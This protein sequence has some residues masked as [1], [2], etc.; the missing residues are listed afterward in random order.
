[1]NIQMIIEHHYIVSLKKIRRALTLTK[2][3]EMIN[4]VDQKSV[5]VRTAFDF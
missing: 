1:M 3:P 5:T 2:K 4:V